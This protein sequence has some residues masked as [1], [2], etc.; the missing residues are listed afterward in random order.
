MAGLGRR[1][2]RRAEPR[3][4][5]VRWRLG[6][7]T[8]IRLSAVAALLTTAAAI[9]WSPPQSCAPPGAGPAPPSATGPSAT[10]SSAAGPSATG[11]RVTASS[12]GTV[13]SVAALSRGGVSGVPS[14]SVG[15]PVR[16]AEPTALTLVHPGD[17]VDLLRIDESGG[18]TTAVAAAALVLGVTD[19]GDPTAGGLLLALKPAEA[20]KAVATAGHGFAV[21]IRPG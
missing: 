2:R 3:L 1:D 5:P 13:P 20:Q 21:L 11:P 17:R 12:A 10:G 16:L 9:I 8:L 7:F 15:V 6:R 19:A 18:G 14:G 4:D